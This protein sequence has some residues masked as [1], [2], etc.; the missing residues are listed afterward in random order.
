MKNTLGN[1]FPFAMGTGTGNEAE[2]QEKEADDDGKMTLDVKS[3]SM[4]QL[5]IMTHTPIERLVPWTNLVW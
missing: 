3:A 1:F 4:A 2:T 5:R